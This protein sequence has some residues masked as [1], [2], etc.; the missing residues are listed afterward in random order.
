MTEKKIK[1]YQWLVPLVIL[2]GLWFFPCPDGLSIKGWH[3]F[4]IFVSTIAGILCSPLPSG[5]LLF[6]ALTISLFTGT[7]SIKVALSGFSSAT[8]W[9]IFSAYVLSL[10]FISSGLGRRVAYTMLSKFGSSSLGVAYA[11]GMADLTIASA[12]PSSAAR[13]GGII[14]PVIKSINLVFDST[15]GEKGKKIGNFLVMSGY[16]VTAVTGSIFLTGMAGNLICMGLANDNLGLDISWA[17][18]F[19]A[20]CV[21]GLLCFMVTPFCTYKLLNPSLKKTPEAKA[22]AKDELQKMGPM[23]REEKLVAIG[24]FGALLGWGTSLITGLNGTAVGI[25][26]I[27]FLFVTKALEW[28][29][30]LK[31]SS[32]WDTVIWF[33]AIISLASAL[34]QLGFIKWMNTGLTAYFAGVDW[35]VALVGLGVLY[36]YLHYMFATCSAHIFALYIPFVSIAIGAGAPPVFACLLFGI[37]TN[38]M[39]GLTEYGGGPGPIYFGQGYFTRP[40][41]YAVG[42]VV[43]TINLII[44]M[45]VGLFWWKAIGL[46]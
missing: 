19:M 41:F 7:T 46:Y 14:L 35:L 30:V 5:A 13:G 37:L 43:V 2:I 20:A 29:Q 10:S 24:F 12:M 40:R 15:P 22:M 42:F 4:A 21:P 38:I 34:N 28:K 26:L 9:L 3:I 39:W 18:W 31:D 17:Q 16:Q 11:M 23:S 32:T 45:G 25:G 44:T 27:S 33:S 36:L 8:V 6:L 1:T